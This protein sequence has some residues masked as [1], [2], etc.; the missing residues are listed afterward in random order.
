M[1]EA[2][3]FTPMDALLLAV[4]VVLAAGA[5]AGYLIACADRARNAGPLVVE[6][7]SPELETLVNNLKD[8]QRFASRAPFAAEEEDTAHVAPGYPYLM[9]AVA[10]VVDPAVRDSTMRWLQCALGTLTA[11]LYFLFARRA[12]QSPVVATLA[13]L[14]C[15]VHPFWVLDT[16]ALAEGVTATFLLA[17][18][19]LLGARASQTSG[20]L[21]SLLYGL[22]LAALALVRAAFLPFAFVALAWFLMRSRSLTRGWLCALL[23]F[24]GFVNG[25]APWTFR[26]WQ[27]YGEPLPIVDSSYYHLWIGNNPHATGGPVSEAMMRDAPVEELAGIRGQAHRY[28]RLGGLVR[29]EVHDQPAETVRRR[30][31]AGLDFVF[32]EHWFTEGRLAERTGSEEAAPDWLAWSYSVV[33]ESTLL[34][35]IV[36]ALLGWRWSYGW[37]GSAMPASLA[38]MWI[39]LPYVLSHAEALSGPRLP[40]DGVLLCYAAFAVA[41]LLPGRGRLWA[42]ESSAVTDSAPG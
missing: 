30:L 33:L 16:A 37:R 5:R 15:A 27:L 10:R 42:G 12:F 3:R 8:K 31:R 11:G 22:S 34:G 6:T 38:A 32:G 21:S 14:L 23:A 13:G 39:P 25:L 19:L 35:L 28:A 17:L 24:L 41:C 26:N 2:R 1:V 9:S 36:L 7:T 20:P 4:V 29:Q 18:S 40:L